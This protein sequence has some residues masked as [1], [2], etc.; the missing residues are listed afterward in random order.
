MERIVA[1]SPAVVPGGRSGMIS[2]APSS[3]CHPATAG[4]L[5]ALRRESIALSDAVADAPYVCLR[6]PTGA[7]TP[8]DRSAGR[9]MILAC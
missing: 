8:L 4:L 3:W 5:A 6:L 9:T 7:R 2:H 1:V